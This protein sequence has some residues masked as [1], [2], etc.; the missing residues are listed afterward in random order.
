MTYQA[1]YG[2]LPTPTRSS[3]YEF[4]GWY[5]AVNGGTQIVGTTKVAITGNQT[6]YAHWKANQFT[7]TF[8]ANGGTTQ[9]STQVVVYNQPYGELPTAERKSYKF[10]GWFTDKDSGT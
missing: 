7:V 8:D 9:Q 5:T 4:D 1:T 10:V 3:S 6:L 2:D